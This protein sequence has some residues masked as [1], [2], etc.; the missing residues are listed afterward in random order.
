MRKHI[1]QCL[2]LFVISVNVY[3]Q[4]KQ[5]NFG[6]GYT[7]GFL[8]AHR[9]D[10]KNLASHNYGLEM[11]Y[12]KSASHLQWGKHYNKPIIGLGLLYY[13][14]GKKETGH[15][16]GPLF[17]VKY[18]VA[19]TK[20][21]DVYFR[22]GAGIG[23]LTRKFSVNDNRRN[24]AIGSKLNGSMQFSVVGHTDF[25]ALGSKYIEYGAAI[26]HYSN[27]A[28]KMPNLGYN[29]PSFFLRY[30]LGFKNTEVRTDTLLKVKPNWIIQ[31]SLIFG[32][33]QRNFASPQSFYHKG[34]QI[35]AVKKH[36]YIKAYRFGIDLL[37]DKT[38][39]YS[40]DVTYPL[41]SI[42]FLDQLEIGASV[43][44]Q[45]NVGQVDIYGEIGAYIYKP[46]VLKDPLYQRM[47]LIYNI[48]D[49]IKMQGAL[50]FHRGVADFFELG[51]A[52]NLVK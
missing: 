52:Y 27:A 50:R 2:I 48:T 24:Q 23:F 51:L 44:Y 42:S 13:N 22:M 17:T 18:N 30:G 40:E 49:K 39:K 31:P 37:L 20:Y 36:N 32:M 11:S 46:A 19:Q 12:E 5:T 35:K 28:F 1:T 14:L 33:K 26:S 7:P 6:I 9:A 3:G 38:Y 15:A 4:T 16:V 47:G 8:L 45:W 10:I 21:T 25:K 29:I 41:D 34:F 43:G